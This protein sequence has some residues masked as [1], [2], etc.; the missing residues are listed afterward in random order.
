LKIF[1]LFPTYTGEKP[2]PVRRKHIKI[3]AVN[4]NDNI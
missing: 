3:D 1:D 2:Q 4:L